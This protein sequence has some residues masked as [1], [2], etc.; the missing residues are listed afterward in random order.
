MNPSIICTARCL[1]V[2]SSAVLVSYL[3]SIRLCRA[4]ID[5]K[6]NSTS[7]GYW[8]PSSVCSEPSV[9]DEPQLRCTWSSTHVLLVPSPLHVKLLFTKPTCTASKHCT[10]RE[11]LRTV[12]STDDSIQSVISE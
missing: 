5:L 4:N 11:D 3:Y 6:R 1:H 9:S 10:L 7:N 8:T 2:V 12:F